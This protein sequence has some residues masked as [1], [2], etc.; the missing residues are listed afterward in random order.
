MMLTPPFQGET[1]MPNRITGTY[2]HSW[3]PGCEN[4]NTEPR[5]C[6]SSTLPTALHT[7]PQCDSQESFPNETKTPNNLFFSGARD[8][9]ARLPILTPMCSACRGSALPPHQARLIL[10]LVSSIRK[11]SISH[12]TGSRKYVLTEQQTYVTSKESCFHRA[13]KGD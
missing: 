10:V 12:T 2:R 13:K 11:H 7:Q 4:W 1:S 3:L 9:R 6:L 5:A 8:N